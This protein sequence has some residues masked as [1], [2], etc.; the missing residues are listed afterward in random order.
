VRPGGLSHLLFPLPNK[1]QDGHRFDDDCQV[2]TVMTRYAITQDTVFGQQPVESLS[3]DT[4]CP[5][6]HI[7]AGT[8]LKGSGIAAQLNLN[9]AY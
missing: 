7:M 6:C 1:S 9:S 8:V 4:M 2:G 5:M 3:H